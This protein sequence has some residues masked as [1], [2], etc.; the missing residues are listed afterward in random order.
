MKTK[1]VDILIGIIG[2]AI[3]FLWES[4]E[5]F[6]LDGFII[7][8][9]SILFVQGLMKAPITK[10]D[11][12]E[13]IA[14]EVTI[15]KKFDVSAF[16]R[17]ERRVFYKKKWIKDNTAFMVTDLLLIIGVMVF[18]MIKGMTVCIIGAAVIAVIWFIVKHNQMM[19]YV[20]K[21]IYS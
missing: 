17:E 12:Q 3:G 1:I 15:D 20:E 19:G 13:K 16:S 21:K 7:G 14:A 4:Q 18:G 6:N 2:I 9:G 5:E 11:E 10:D 8:V